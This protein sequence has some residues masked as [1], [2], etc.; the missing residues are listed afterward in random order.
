MTSRPAWRSFHAQEE[1]ARLAK[2]L[3]A[4]GVTV[5]VVDGLEVVEVEQD[6]RNVPA[7]AQR[8]RAARGQASGL[9][10]WEG[11]HRRRR[12]AGEGLLVQRSGPGRGI[13]RQEH[14]QVT[15]RGHP[16]VRHL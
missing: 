4:D 14:R 16:R 3:V 9:R 11:E 6:E 5:R 2:H 8:P 7:L 13:D 12:V 15:D 1:P 10:E